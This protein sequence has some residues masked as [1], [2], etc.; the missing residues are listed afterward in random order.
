MDCASSPMAS[1]S[2]CS[3]VRIIAWR[4]FGCLNI[5]CLCIVQAYVPER[6]LL[7]YLF[8]HCKLQE[9]SRLWPDQTLQFITYLSGDNANLDLCSFDSRTDVCIILMDLICNIYIYE[10]QIFYDVVVLNCG[11]DTS[12]HVVFF[13]KSFHISLNF[14]SIFGVCF[15][16]F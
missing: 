15:L 10:T 3:C 5:T 7:Y 1:S 6:K 4:V 9:S 8:V 11:R 14:S 2:T 13:S 16:F 12:M